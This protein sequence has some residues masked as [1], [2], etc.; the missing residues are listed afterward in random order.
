MEARSQA[1]AIRRPSVLADLVSLTK[2]RVISLLLVTT[3]APMFATGR[4]APPLGLVLVVLFA[5]Y[6][7]AGGANAINMWFDRDIDDRMAR[8]RLRPLPAGRLAPPVALAFGIGLALVAFALFWRLVN[9]LSAGLA[10]GGLLFYVFVYTVWLKRS[11]PQNIVIGGAAGAFPPLVGWAAM[12]N[13]I[14]L[15]AVYLFAIIFYWTPPHFWALALI[16]RAEYARA[17]V[18][19]MPVVRGEQRTKAEM[20]IYTLMLLP[21]S[22]MPVL[23]DAFGWFYAAAAALLGAPLLWYC[24]RL[25][26]EPGVTPT[27]WKLYRYSLLYLA[28]LFV[29][30]SVDRNLPSAEYRP[31]RV[32]ILSDPVAGGGAP[33]HHGH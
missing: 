24:I 16:K 1:V 5:G 14:D 3:I 32:L 29:A 18:P 7:M 12:T 31:D 28:L 22:L 25:I 20:L 33:A 17:G 15:P 10:L 6:L 9:P 13:R 27:A 26:R 4:G 8:T 23:F 11:S 21:L 19:M 30:M 2:P